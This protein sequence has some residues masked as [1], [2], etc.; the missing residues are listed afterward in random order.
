MAGVS[1]ETGSVPDEM[2]AILTEGLGNVSS[3]A[4]ETQA[5]FHSLV[6]RVKTL[7]TNGVKI[8]STT[9][10]LLSKALLSLFDP[11]GGFVF[12]KDH[13]VALVGS[14]GNPLEEEDIPPIAKSHVVKLQRYLTEANKTLQKIEKRIS[15][16]LEVG[17]HSVIN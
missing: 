12:L 16:H 9:W 5:A 11:T 3:L 8:S 2:E 14:F 13:V 4:E 10:K 1:S 7:I 15:K 6:N 17:F